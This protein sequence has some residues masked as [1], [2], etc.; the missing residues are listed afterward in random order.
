MPK[1]YNYVRKTQRYNGK[2]Y[3]AAGKTEK[4]AVRLRTCNITGNVVKYSRRRAGGGVS[5]DAKIIKYRTRDGKG[6]DVIA[7][8]KIKR[9]PSHEVALDCPICGRHTD[10]AVGVK[11]I[12]SSNFTDWA[13][14]GDYVC[15]DCADLF[16]LYFYSYVVDPDGIRLLNVRE[17]RDA[18]IT[19]QK[20][21]FLFCVTTSR[22][23]HLFYRA[24][25]N[26]DAGHFA[27]NLEA[28]SRGREIS[29]TKCYT[30]GLPAYMYRYDGRNYYRICP[31]ANWDTKDVGAYI[32]KNGLPTLDWYEKQGIKSRTASRISEAGI[33][34]N[35]LYWLKV[36]N[37]SGYYQL[38]KRFPE[39]AAIT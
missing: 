32:Q 19:P 25:W 11:D 38:L 10:R 16:S 2:K 7:D 23:K 31:L 33:A 18:L 6:N 17:L 24:A 37:P 9:Y 39:L 21:P 29:L 3:E 26:H 1:K 36:D 28:E 22:K 5:V 20:T 34:C 12:V 35:M 15:P 14:V 13:F 4:E 27:V 8:V 30:H